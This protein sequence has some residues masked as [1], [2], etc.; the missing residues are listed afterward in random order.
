VPQIFWPIVLAVLIFGAETATL[1]A[2]ER[3]PIQVIVSALSLATAASIWWSILRV[4]S[5]E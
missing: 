5:K 4:R 3:K 2:I 1:F